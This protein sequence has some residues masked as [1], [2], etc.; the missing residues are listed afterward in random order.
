MLFRSAGKNI[1]VIFHVDSDN[2]VNLAGMAVDDFTVKFAGTVAS[3]VPVAG[4]VTD[5][6]G[7]A[8]GAVR[9]NLTDENGE[10]YGA[11]S[12]P[13][14]YYSVPN[15]P[16]GHTYVLSATARRYTFNNRLVTVSDEI[17]DADLVANP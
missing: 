8:I 2:T 7:R 5:A 13:F 10:V 4:R 6:D 16:A 17:G 14:G 12:N 9:I 15:V 1:Q 11:V 3:R